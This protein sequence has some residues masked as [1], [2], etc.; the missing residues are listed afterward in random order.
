MHLDSCDE[1][2]KKLLAMKFIANPFFETSFLEKMRQI[3]VYF[4]DFGKATDY[5]QLKIIEATE[6]NTENDKF[7][8]KRE[9]AEYIQD[10][11]RLKKRIVQADQRGADEDRLTQH[12]KLGAYFALTC[13]KE[14]DPILDGILIRIIRR[15]HG[16][17][18]NF[19]MSLSWNPQ[20]GLDE[21]ESELLE[22]QVACTAFEAYQ[23]ILP[24]GLTVRREDWAIL[25]K[26]FLEDFRTMPLQ[27]KLSQQPDIRYFFLQHLMFSLL[28][29]ADK[30]D[31][32]LKG[33]EKIKLLREKQPLPLNLIDLHKRRAFGGKPSQPIDAQRE[34]AYQAV[35][36]NAKKYGK[37]SF[38]SITLP[39]GLGKTL[40]AYNAAILLQQAFIE[41]TKTDARPQGVVPRIVYTLPFTSIIDQ[42]CAIF[43]EILDDHP[44][45]STT[46]LTKNHYLS[47]Y[48]EQYALEAQSD[49]AEVET[50]LAVSE[51]EYLAEGWEQEVIV[52]TFIQFLEG[53]FTNKNRDLRKFHN[54]TNAIF[55]LD[56][57]QA[58]PTKYYGAIEFVMRNMAAFF[59]TKFI[60]VTATQPILFKKQADII[61]LTDPTFRRTRQFFEDEQLN[62]MDIDQTLLKA[63]DYGAMEEQDF[64]QILIQDIENQPDKSF[65]IIVNTIA[66]SQW[67]YNTLEK[68]LN[69]EDNQL[70]Y[71]SSSI[72]P[73][74]RLEVIEAIKA[75]GGKRKIVVSTQVVEAGVDIDLDR[76]YR[77][78]AP[79]DSINQS[80]GRCN[81]NKLK[82]RGI[83][84]L[85]H[86]G[87][88]QYVYRDTSLLEITKRILKSRPAFIAENQLFELNNEYAQAVRAGNTDLKNDSDKLIKAMQQLQLEDVAAAFTL[89]PDD[90]RFLDVF[91]PCE[92]AAEAIW[93]EYEACRKIENPFLRKDALKAIQPK[94]LQYVTRFPKKKYTIPTGEE[95]A[96][97][98]YGRNWKSFY[99]LILGFELK[100][101]AIQII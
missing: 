72:L 36:E 60:F 15:H 97:L 80:A 35:A 67:I 70:L 82:G 29:S 48:N 11:K 40:T 51:A 77:D 13:F 7:K 1:I 55:I 83:V 14:T 90:N 34:S 25:K 49:E 86:L 4:H 38:F 99:D 23:Q 21:D 27:E 62:R 5:F 96:F 71:L 31:M 74:K 76:V 50:A 2:S 54:M 16:Y 66:Q 18:T 88:C 56:E 41:Q 30:G 93:K 92:A 98:I 73:F 68:R 10:F 84:K 100:D 101:P 19:L 59:N 91:V 63:S 20:I 26:R 69:L 17:L 58:I 43:K 24:E 28:L 39:T 47:A 33:E 42:N 22:R 89:I 9:I 12:A 8:K 53:I 37:A 44:D 61:E 78:F 32:M 81:R 57:V 52:T 95:K 6:K 46:W 65:L 79:I 85:F 75:K 64:I 3:L 94:L 45:T 87:K